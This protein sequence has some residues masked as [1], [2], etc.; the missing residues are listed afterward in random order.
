[1]EGNAPYSTFSLLRPV[2]ISYLTFVLLFLAALLSV[3]AV[4]KTLRTSPFSKLT[5]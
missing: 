5:L 4:V 2:L 1:M 3:F